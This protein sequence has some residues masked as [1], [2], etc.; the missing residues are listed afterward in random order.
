MY[1]KLINL[2]FLLLKFVFFQVIEN[3][4]MLFSLMSIHFQFL[5]LNA[6]SPVNCP[7]L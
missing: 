5:H 2:F 4:P 7:S 1:I 3:L 6:L